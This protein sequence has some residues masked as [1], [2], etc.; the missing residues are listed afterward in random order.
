MKRSRNDDD[1]ADPTQRL[2]AVDAEIATLEAQLAERR[3][4]RIELIEASQRRADGTAPPGFAAALSRRTPLDTTTLLQLLKWNTPTVFNGWE[5]ITANPSYGRECFNLEPITDHAPIFGPMLGYALTVRI[6]P[7]D[8]TVAQLAANRQRFR[9]HVASLPPQHPKIVVVEDADK[10]RIYGSM[11]GEVNATFFKAI[12]AVGCITDG[13]VRDLD[14]MAAVGFHAMSRGVCIGHSFGGVPIEWDVPV[15]VF[16]VTVRPGQLIHADK[17]G[18]LV[19]P[20]EDEPRLLEATEFMDLLERKHTI[21]PGREAAVTAA[22]V[23]DVTQAMAAATQ[24]FGEEKNQAY[25]TYAS[26]F[27]AAGAE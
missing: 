2:A 22:S 5:Q 8:R 25:G 7:G 17:H 13:G 1:A 27:P 9:E 6:S 16:G 26:R 20:E 3:R 18:F 21:V 24:R 19:V 10:P 23:R 4:E 15:N 14:E 12:G 11:W